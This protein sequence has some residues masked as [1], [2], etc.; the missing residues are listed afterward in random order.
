MRMV[1]QRYVPGFEFEWMDIFRYV[2]EHC[3]IFGAVL[4]VVYHKS[5]ESVLL[6]IGSGGTYF[7]NEIFAMNI[8]GSFI[9]GSIIL[10]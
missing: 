5:T 7:G 6:Y 8:D 2:V 9:V 3:H 10:L 1:G 4:S